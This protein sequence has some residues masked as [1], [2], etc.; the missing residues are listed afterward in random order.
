LQSQYCNFLR[1]K[2]AWRKFSCQNSKG[3][4]EIPQGFRSPPIVHSPNTSTLHVLKISLV[5]L[6]K[7]EINRSA[8]SNHGRQ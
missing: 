7:S 5:N 2:M 6:V 1:K 8:N 3:E 4:L